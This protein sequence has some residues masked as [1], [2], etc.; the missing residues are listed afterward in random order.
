MHDLY[1]T[2]VNSVQLPIKSYSIKT[3]AAY[4]GFQWKG[5]AGWDAAYHDYKVWVQ[6][7]QAAAL[8]RACEYQRDDVLA[9]VVVWQWMMQSQSASE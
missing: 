4:F 1:K 3:V 6:Q 7:D 5:H 9:M 2:F 8:W